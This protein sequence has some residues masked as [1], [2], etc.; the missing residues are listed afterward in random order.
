[1]SGIPWTEAEKIAL[2]ASFPHSRWSDISAALPGRSRTAIIQQ[3]RLWK[4]VREINKRE[5]WTAFEEG[6]IRKLY[7]A[8]MHSEIKAALPGRA[9]DSIVKKANVLGVRRPTEAYRNNSRFIHPIIREL[10]L[11]RERRRITRPQLSSKLGY[12]VNQ[13]C[14]WEMGKTNPDFGAVSLW[15][16]AL[17]MELTL[18]PN[19]KQLLAEQSQ[20]LPLRKLM[21]G[22]A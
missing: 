16:E 14:C 17:G 19:A 7:P 5:R 10:R 6:L 4:V 22:R 18:R 8:A 3:A 12:H 2:E 9:W 11:E 13:L 15:A 1:M 21:A 20:V